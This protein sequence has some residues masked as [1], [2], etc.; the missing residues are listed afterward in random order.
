[1]RELQAQLICDARCILA[2]GPV[3]FENALWFVDIEGMRFHR[4]DV[5]RTILQTQQLSQR[6]GFAVPVGPGCFVVGLQSGI[7]TLDWPL[8]TTRHLVS[9]E[10]EKTANRMNDGKADPEG[11][12]VAGTM[13]LRGEKQ[14]G[15]LYQCCPSL[16]VSV[17]IPGVTIS[18]GLDWSPAG[19]EM[20]YIDTP[21]RQIMVYRYDRR[22][23]TISEGRVFYEVPPDW[24]W[25]D[26]LCTDAEGNLWVAFW[27]GSAVRCLS[28]G[29]GELL[30]T[31]EVAAR[32]VTSCCFGGW[33]YRQL[34]ITTARGGLPEEA[35]RFPH[36]GGIFQCTPGVT[37]KPPT[38]C[39]VGRGTMPHS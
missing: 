13:S 26:G 37:G 5:G 24:G 4:L 1:M 12:L 21:T 33:G 32:H 19:T 16:Q 23:G 36:A 22:K 39:R 3:W 20:Y 18:N 14:A 11:R 31:V 29:S 2:E 35:K 38:L 30:A 34:F 7:Y 25:P 27:G 17:L 9:P 10:P 28:A 15:C 6:I 8:G